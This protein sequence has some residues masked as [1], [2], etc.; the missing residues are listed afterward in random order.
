MALVMTF[1]AKKISS[2]KYYQGLENQK[3]LISQLDLFLEDKDVVITLSTAG[4]APK[5]LNSPDIKDSCL[6]WTL[7]HVPA[8][9]LPVFKGPNTLPFGAQIVS[10]RYRDNDLLGFAQL[11][12]DKNLL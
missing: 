3:R 1:M 8:V 7:C 4:E 12:E 2:E 5:G 6:I 10:G 9:N 11:L